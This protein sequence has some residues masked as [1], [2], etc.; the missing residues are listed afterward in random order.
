MNTR[1]IMMIAATLL[2]ASACDD[3]SNTDAGTITVDVVRPDVQTPTDTPAADAA[4]DVSADIASDTASDGSADA[5]SDASAD[6]TTDAST[7]ASTD[8]GAYVDGC[9]VGTPS[10][11]TDFLN[12]CGGAVA[13]PPRAAR[14]TRLTADGGVQPLAM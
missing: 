1:S 8:G 6:V 2:F 5:T 12:R 11:M 9:F 3:S 13:F 7:D 14:G 10:S 4:T